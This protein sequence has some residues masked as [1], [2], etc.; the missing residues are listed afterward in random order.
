MSIVYPGLTVNDTISGSGNPVRKAVRVATVSAGTLATDFEN[1]DTLDGVTLVTNDRILIKNQATASENGIY[2]VQASGAPLRASDYDTGDSGG[3]ITVY[4]KEGTVHADTG[5]FCINDDGSDIIGTNNLSYQQT[6]GSGVDGNMNGPGSSTAN[7]LVR[8][9]GTAGTDVLDSGITLD[10]SNNMS[11]FNTIVFETGANDV[12]ITATTQTVG[13]GTLNIPD[14]ANA[15]TDIVGLS[16]TQTLTNKTLSTGSTW[17]GNTIGVANGGTGNTSFTVGNVLVGNGA[18]AISAT[19]A[20]PTG[21]FVGT[22]DTQTLTNKTLTTPIISQISNT[23]V[24]TL[25]TATTT[26]VGTNTTDTLTNKTISSASNTITLSASTITSGTLP[27]ARGGTGATTF[28]SGNFLQGNGT[29][30]VTATKVVPTGVVVGTTDTQ[31]LTNKTLTSPRI[32]TAILDTNGNELINLTATGSAVNEL[33][34]AN[35]ATSNNPTLSATG[36]DT[37]IGMNFQVKGTGVYRFL[38]TTT[39]HAELQLYEDTDNGTNYTAWAAPAAIT[40]TTT[41]RMPDGVGTNG[42]V[43]ST[44]GNNPATLSWVDSATGVTIT[45]V[46]S[47]LEFQSTDDNYTTIGSMTITP[48]AG[49]Y[50]VSYSANNAVDNRNTTYKLAIFSN[51]TIVTHTERDRSH[52]NAN[53]FTSSQTQ[54]EVTVADGQAIE[55]RVQRTAGN[56][57][58]IIG[59]RSLILIS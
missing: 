42:Q 6:S 29:G 28:T 38:G 44:D 39:S 32:G 51:G 43:L 10:G 3:G 23:G 36:G 33:T 58:I 26:L 24:L 34:L 40:T 52:A 25:P 50:Y 12:T 37:N 11:G 48:G 46:S 41:L 9:N 15:T 56:G 57:S 18:S 30:A 55:V 5:W 59:N 14:L 4:V 54:C 21:N 31:T 19:K 13:A 7:A 53:S 35:A 45:Q 22:T 16:L 27:V 20:A 2:I 17:S 49:T 1:G 8:W 47:T